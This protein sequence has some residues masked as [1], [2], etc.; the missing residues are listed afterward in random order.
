V[1]VCK[2]CGAPK[3]LEAFPRNVK[4]A[5]GRANYCREC[6]NRRKR[7]RREENP[8]VERAHKRRERRL[9]PERARGHKERER[10]AKHAQVMAHAA[11]GRA[12]GRGDLVRPDRCEWC[13]SDER[14]VGHH[15]DYA[16]QLE[17]AWICDRCHRRHHAEIERRA[18]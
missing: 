16:K 5:D 3:A 14:L 10:V 2:D 1:K 15:E 11:V 6:T 18:A 12:L 8:E 7:E 17:V 9:H 4:A 13:G